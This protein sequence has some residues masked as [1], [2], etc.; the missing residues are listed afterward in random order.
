MHPEAAAAAVLLPRLP[1]V[2]RV[3]LLMRLL[4]L[5]APRQKGIIQII[6]ILKMMV[7][8]QLLLHSILL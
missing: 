8:V 7:M 5:S 1:I 4:K 6:L 2:L 3:R